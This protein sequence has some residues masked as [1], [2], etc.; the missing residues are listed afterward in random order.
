MKL[1]RSA[2]YALVAVGHIARTQPPDPVLAKSIAKQHKIPLD[3][4]LK[5]LQQLVRA[6][7]LRSIRGPRGGFLL[8]RSVSRISLLQIIE[9]VDGPFIGEPTLC[10]THFDTPYNRRVTT[11]YQQATKL[12]A[13]ILA[14][15]NL[16]TLIGEKKRPATQKSAKSKKTAKSKKKTKKKTNR[17]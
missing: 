7:V 15:A 14:Q 6:N 8:A 13:K 3:Y 16:A 5:I 4:L 1:T 9:A 10:T 11:V 17:R 12:A 2:S